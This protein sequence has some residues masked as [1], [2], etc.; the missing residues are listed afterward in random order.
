MSLHVSIRTCEHSWNLQLWRVFWNI[1]GTE[2]PFRAPA[3]SQSAPILLGLFHDPQNCPWCWART[4]RSMVIAVWYLTDWLIIN[5]RSNIPDGL[6]W[7]GST[8]NHHSQTGK[9]GF[10]EFHA[11]FLTYSLQISVSSAS[12]I[13]C[14]FEV[15]YSTLKL[16]NNS[17]KSVTLSSQPVDRQNT[18]FELGV[19]TL[20][21]TAVLRSLHGAYR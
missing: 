21:F 14:T 4:A 3:L 6:V 13:L 2:Y 10:F 17:L 18:C 1:N 8:R 15:W 11:L 12:N 7:H 16:W 20:S 9:A 5:Q 19:I